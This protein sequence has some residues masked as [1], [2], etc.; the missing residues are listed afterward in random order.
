MAK[1]KSA[2]SAPAFF[3]PVTFLLPSCRQWFQAAGKVVPRGPE[4]LARNSFQRPNER[5]QPSAP[6]V[7]AWATLVLRFSECRSRGGSI[8]SL[9][10]TCCRMFHNGTSFSKIFSFCRCSYLCYQVLFCPRPFCYLSVAWSASL[11]CLVANCDKP[12]SQFI[13]KV[14]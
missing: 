4:S 11:E 1:D 8:E 10:C 13:S 14:N 2:S 6:L 12:E 5:F 9:V 7:Q 3:F